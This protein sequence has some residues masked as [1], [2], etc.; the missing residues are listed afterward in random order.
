[1]TVSLRLTTL[2][3]GAAASPRYRP[4]GLLIDAGRVRVMMDGGPGAAPAGELAAWLVTDEQSELIADIRRLGRRRGLLPRAG[5][6]RRRCLQIER[7]PV[8][9]TSH[10]AW[11][12]R[13]TWGRRTVV[14]A[15]EF[16]RFPRWAAGADLMFA[17]AAGWDRP[18]RFAGGVGGHLDALAV[19]RAAARQG[20]RR[21]VYAHIGRPTI[22]AIDRGDRPPFGEF[23]RDGQ[24]FVLRSTA[25]AN[26][27]PR[28]NE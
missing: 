5:S 9:H 3:V 18:I 22:R 7:R 2:G 11:G 25:P 19:A 6:F 21:L 16:F 4:A 27:G 17:E 20:V 1:M 12:Y 13:I 15:P 10:P 26:P 8:V 24:L 23:A 14:W 28:R